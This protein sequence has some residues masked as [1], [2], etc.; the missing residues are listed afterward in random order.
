MTPK[1][2]QD[3]NSHKWCDE[4]RKIGNRRIVIFLICS[5][6]YI[7]F[8][9]ANDAFVRQGLS[10]ESALL[11]SAAP[12]WQRLIRKRIAICWFMLAMI[13]D[14]KIQVLN[15]AYYSPIALCF[16][17]KFQ[18]LLFYVGLSLIGKA[19]LCE[20][21]RCGFKSRRSTQFDFVLRILDL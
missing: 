5:C 11:V 2:Q 9:T 10:T 1:Y 13:L 6:S 7:V 3:K 8:I 17:G 14:W 21:G 18:N 20:R 15:H 16:Q 12:R 4:N 19:P